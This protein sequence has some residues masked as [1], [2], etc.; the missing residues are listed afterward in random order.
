MD[1]PEHVRPARPDEAE[2][3]T[4]LAVRSKRHWGYEP[5]LLA[6]FRGALLISPEDILADETWVLERGDGRVVGFCRVAAGDPAVLEDLWLDPPAIGQGGGRRLWNV[7]TA[8]ARASGASAIELDA[9]PNAV[10]FYERMGARRVGDTPSSVV[11][12]RLLP[13]MRL[14]LR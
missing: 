3:L 9:D 6:Q 12:G 8:R 2:A 13:R 11:S 10:G 5:A 4:E 14:E 7:A 1:P